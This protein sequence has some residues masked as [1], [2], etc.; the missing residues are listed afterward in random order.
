MYALGDTQNSSAMSFIIYRSIIWKQ[1]NEEKLKEIDYIEFLPLFTW[2]TEAKGENAT[3][4][5]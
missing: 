2:H 4:I 3:N 1:G 5:E